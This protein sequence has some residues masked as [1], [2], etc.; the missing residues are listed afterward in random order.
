MTVRGDADDVAPQAV[1][2]D[3]PGSSWRRRRSS[4]SPTRRSGRRRPCPR[5]VTSWTTPASS[6]ARARRSSGRRGPPCGAGSSSAGLGGGVAAGDADPG[7]RGRGGAWP[8]LLGLWWLNACRIVYV[9]DEA[10]PVTRFG[11]AYGTLPG[12]AGSGRG[13]VPGRV[14]P[15]ERGGLVRHPGLL[16]PAQLPDPAGIPVHAAGPGAIREGVGGGDGEGREG[17]GRMKVPVA[18]ASSPGIPGRP[19]PEPYEG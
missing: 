7:R 1:R 19:V 3:D 6:W 8:A 4:T 14:G 17:R 16:P 13:A 12:H 18:P 9:V 11:F 5:R 10:G 2:R 15:G